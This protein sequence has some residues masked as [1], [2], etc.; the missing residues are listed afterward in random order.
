MENRKRNQQ[1]K[2]SKNSIKK[3]LRK[4]I[5]STLQ[6]ALGWSPKISQLAGSIIVGLLS[7]TG[8]WHKKIAHTMNN[9]NQTESN[10]RSIQRFF[11][12]TY[13]NY[14]FFSRMIY[15]ILQIRGK[16]TIIIDRTNWDF[17]KRHINILVA[18][19]L[20]QAAQQSQSFA[21]PLVW[22]VFDKKG[23]SNTAERKKLMQ[24]LIAIV[25]VKNIEVLLADREFIGQEW[26]QFLNEHHIPFVIRIRKDMYVEYNGKKVNAW[27]LFMGMKYKEERSYEVKLNGIPVALAGTC[28]TEGELVVV[29]ASLDVSGKPLSEYRLRWLIE[30]FFKSIK[31][32][33]FNI[34]ETHMADPERIK[35]LFALISY[36]TVLTVQAGILYNHFKQ[37]PTKNHGRPSYSLFTYGLDLLRTLFRGVIPN[38]M[39][40][41]LELCAKS[42]FHRLPNANIAISMLFDG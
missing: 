21:V 10:I 12:K 29:V 8:V 32:Q 18:A 5:V 25:G 15:D 14:H 7:I 22:E 17:G 35:L 36:A 42:P 41:V 13:I 34:E 26:I 40:Q 37:I 23:N 3:K 2:Q 31:T 9:E 24:E 6:K 16:V 11:C 38:R 39:K 30:L 28:S 1:K 19:V 27:T 33:G 4:K 20:C